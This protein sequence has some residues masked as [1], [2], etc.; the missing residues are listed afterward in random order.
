MET[1]TVALEKAL[2]VLINVVMDDADDEADSVGLFT[3]AV[4][5][6]VR[7]LVVDEV[8]D[9]DGD[10]VKFVDPDDVA[11]SE[12]EDDNDDKDVTVPLLDPLLVAL[13]EEVED[14]ILE[15]DEVIVATEDSET[16]ADGEEELE[17]L[18]ESVLHA[19]IEAIFEYVGDEDEVA[20]DD[21]QTVD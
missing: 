15:A 14:V 1:D 7:I 9:A 8:E 5:V 21:E 18:D 4:G 19:E 17:G 2:K 13:I 12:D 11:L 10:I 6:T 20:L 3:L 16:S